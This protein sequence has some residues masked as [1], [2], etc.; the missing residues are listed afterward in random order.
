VQL[1]W[2]PLASIAEYVISVEPMGKVIGKLGT[3]S[4]H[5]NGLF[6]ELSERKGFTIR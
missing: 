3:A 6:P 2:F 1:A 5:T 4:D